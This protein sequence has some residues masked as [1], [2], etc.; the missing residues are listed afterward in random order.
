MVTAAGETIYPDEVEP[1][2]ASPLFAEWCVVGRPG[3][4]GNDVPTLF[5]VPAGAEADESALAEAF[6]RLRAAAPS[7]YRVDHMIPLD[8]PLPR[9]ALGKPRRRA[10][11]D[12]WRQQTSTLH[13]D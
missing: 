8:H 12:A 2:Y 1:Y 3:P 6:Q 13:H 10:I 11:A 7:R 9:T 4:D 5:V